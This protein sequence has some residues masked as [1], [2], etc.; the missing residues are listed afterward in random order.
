MW[1]NF[2]ST[3]ANADSW[4]LVMRAGTVVLIVLMS[5]T[6]SSAYSVLTHEEIVDLPSTDEI[7]PL[8]LHRCPGLSEE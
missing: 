3:G 6:S 4:R 7:R 5:C 8:F 2:M 1:H